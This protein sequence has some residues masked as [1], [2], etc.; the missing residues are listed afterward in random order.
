MILL[1]EKMKPYWDMAHIFLWLLENSTY[2]E[3]FLNT[4]EDFLNEHLKKHLT[5]KEKDFFVSMQGVIEKIKDKENRS[6]D[7]DE[8]EKILLWIE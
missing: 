2:D 3:W 8:A 5:E 4:L 1:L 7:F 6:E